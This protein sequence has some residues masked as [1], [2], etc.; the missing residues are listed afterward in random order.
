MESPESLS[1]R[2]VVDLRWPLEGL[3]DPSVRIGEIKKA[4]SLA[5]VD[6]EARTHQPVMV[7]ELGVRRWADTS[8][9]CPSAGKTYT[10]IAAWG[11]VIALAHAGS[12]L[13]QLKPGASGRFPELEYHAGGGQVVYCGAV[14]P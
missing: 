9:D 10:A 8:F 12:D 1:A 4:V 14:V 2:T 13:N 7:S 5:R 11:Y 3:P 6:A